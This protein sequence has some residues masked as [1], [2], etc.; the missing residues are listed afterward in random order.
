MRKAIC[1]FG[2]I[3]LALLL[4]S[5]STAPT[6]AVS[7]TATTSADSVSPDSILSGGA[8]QKIALIVPLSGGLGAT[9]D[10]IRNG[11][12]SAYYY[13]KSLNAD[14]P[15][16]V[17]IDSAG[18]NIQSAYQQALSEGATFIVGPLTKADV[19]SLISAG[20]RQ[21]PVLALNT[22]AANSKSVYQFGLPPEDEAIQVAERMRQNGL[23]RTLIIAPAGALGQRISSA[24]IARYQQLGGTVVDQLTYTQSTNFT[25]AIKQLLNFKSSK[26]KSIPPT[27]RE[28]FDSVFMVAFPAQARQIRPMLKFYYADAIPVYA[29]SEVY[30]GIPNAAQDNDLSGVVFADMPWIIDGDQQ[31]NGTLDALHQ[32]VISL[33]PQSYAN[34]PRFYALGIDAYLLAN[35]LNSGRSSSGIQGATG[36]LYIDNSNRVIRV[37]S[38]GQFSDGLVVPK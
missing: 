36:L 34:Y 6:R 2:G 24:F 15:Q 27:R 33:W 23:D 38:W 20:D 32:R 9:G 13:A 37:V 22:V 28:D 35:K 29:T 1:W 30:K 16:I 5:C 21:V 10:A 12:F 17:L 4:A 7:G 3:L 26:N 31:S 19:S 25:Q 11:F 14:A 8:P 18:K